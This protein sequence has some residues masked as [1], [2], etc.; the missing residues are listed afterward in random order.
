M[1]KFFGTLD[2][3]VNHGRTAVSGPYS[4]RFDFLV[5]RLGRSDHEKSQDYELSEKLIKKSTSLLKNFI[6]TLSGFEILILQA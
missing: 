6:P 1:T 3:V 4:P 5:W 2:R